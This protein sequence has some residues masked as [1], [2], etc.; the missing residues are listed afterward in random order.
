MDSEEYI[1]ELNRRVVEDKQPSM[2]ERI[3]KYN[4]EHRWDA[5]DIARKEAGRNQFPAEHS[6]IIKGVR[7]DLL[8][9]YRITRSIQKGE[10]TMT[11][12]QKSVLYRGLRIAVFT[13]LA[14]LV[15]YLLAN[16]GVIV[17]GGALQPIIISIVAAGLAA[18][19]KAIRE[20][21]AKQ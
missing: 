19:D 5:Y 3:D 13:G 11:E 9:I 14:T 1:R 7:I 10:L 2:Q 16:L 4:A 17:P 6:T 18:A 8:K 15:S 21:L 20:A 12:I